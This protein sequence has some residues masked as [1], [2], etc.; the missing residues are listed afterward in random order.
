VS[1]TDARLPVRRIEGKLSPD[2]GWPLHSHGSVPQAEAIR[3]GH[4]M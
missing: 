3:G 2:L 1:P 4:F